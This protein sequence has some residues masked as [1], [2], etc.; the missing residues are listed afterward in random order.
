MLNISRRNDWQHWLSDVMRLDP[1]SR[2]KCRTTL[3]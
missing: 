3:Q 1:R 2:P